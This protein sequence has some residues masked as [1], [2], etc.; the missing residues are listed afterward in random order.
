VFVED[1]GVQVFGSQ[2]PKGKGDVGL[3]ALP[4]RLFWTLQTTTIRFARSVSRTAIHC[5]NSAG[6][7]PIGVHIHS[8][9]QEELTKK[10]RTQDRLMILF[11]YKKID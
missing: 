5:K 2:F 7:R 9:A 6:G 3:G 4:R 11:F 10:K 1:C 8:C